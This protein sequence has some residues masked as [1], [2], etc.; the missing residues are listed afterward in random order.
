MRAGMAVLLP[1]VAFDIAGP[2]VVQ[3]VAVTRAPA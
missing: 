3:G 2:I 1:V